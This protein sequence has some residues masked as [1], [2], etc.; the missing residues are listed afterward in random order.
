MRENIRL[1]LKGIWSHRLR[2]FLTMLGVIIG[3][4]SIIAI[5]STIKG[6]NE[7]IMQNLIGTGNNNVTVSLRQGDSEYWMEA[8]MPDNVIPVTDSQIREIRELS[9]VADA[10]FY[11]KRRYASEITAGVNFLSGGSI[12]GVDSHYLT[13]VGYLVYKGRPFVEADYT[14]FRKTALL[15]EKAA[16][17]LFPGVDPIGSTVDLLGEPFIVVGLIR[18]A[19]NF[20]PV[21][22]SLRDYE[23]Y[24]GDEY[25]MVLIPDAD[26]PILY[27]YDEPQDCVARAVSTEKMSDVGRK[28]EQIMKKSV[29]GSGMGEDAVTYKAEDLLEKAR[30]KQELANSTNNLLIWIASIALLVG[31]IGVMNIMLVSVTERTNEIG[32]KK[33]LGARNSRILAQ[34]LTEAVVLTSLGGVA[35]VISGI[36][37]A[38]VISR[39]AGTPVAISIPAIILSVLF[40]MAIGVIFGFLPSVQAANLNPIDALRRE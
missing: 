13:T 30:N 31:G 3:I 24:T 14:N 17:L 34:F 19:D 27:N 36:I 32:L 11:Y 28:V 25:G 12:F 23:T 20:Q 7:Q 40:S 10:S 35:G 2:S 33:A 22:E 4:A 18:K 38:E 37:L 16:E 29:G 15:D 26:W 1:A 9:G 21:I 5:V 8:G 6:T 39:A